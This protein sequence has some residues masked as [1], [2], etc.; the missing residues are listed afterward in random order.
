MKLVIISHTEHYK[1]KNGSIVGWGPTITEINHLTAIFETIV[2]IGMLYPGDAPKSA[3]PYT[4]SSI[5]F[6]PIPTVGGS[7]LSNKLN[8][9]IAAPKTI[10][11]VS[12]YLKISDYFQLRTP[13]GIGVYLIPYLSWFHRSQ[14]WYKYAGNWN[15]NSAPI[16]YAFQRWFLKNQSRKVTINGEWAK[17]P[18]HCITFENP[19]LTDDDL[20]IG[21]Q[22]TAHKRKSDLIDFCYVGRLETPK[23]VGR[24]IASI[25][26]LEAKERD[27]IGVIHLV[28]DGAERLYFE[29]QA[30]LRSV[31][32][33]FHG[34]LNREKV[35]EIYKQCHG[36]L[37]PT[38]ASEGF[39]KVLAEAMNFG[40]VPIVSSISSINQYIITG[41]TGF[42]LPQVNEQALA[43]CITNFINMTQTDYEALI[44]KGQ[45]VVKYFTFSYYNE[46]IK[47]AILN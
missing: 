30:K 15:Q 23:G 32:F 12:K 16:G 7:G 37:M 14:G 24:I 22:V 9:L 42:V 17:Q 20:I 38:T 35:F 34:F 31:N 28:G 39:P 33:K 27:K 21:E 45:D 8:I 11:L 44:E 13:T 18:K 4:S 47:K 41:E 5:Q 43:E 40:C 29:Q 2:H 1:H 26:Q 3:L 46:H 25:D 36:F 19:C 10:S 6:V